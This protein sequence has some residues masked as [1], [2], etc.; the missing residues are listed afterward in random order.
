MT[1]T[2]TKPVAGPLFK[3]AAALPIEGGKRRKRLCLLA[4]Y[5]DA[6]EPSPRVRDLARIT[7][8]EVPQIDQLLRTL[9]RD[10]HLNV[11]WRA[12]SHQQRR[13]VYE[14]H[15]TTTTPEEGASS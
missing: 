1:A 3:Q 11:R 8:F 6:G 9:Q 10:G 4:A 5:A 7:G 15:L 12:S 2:K 13:N 14:L